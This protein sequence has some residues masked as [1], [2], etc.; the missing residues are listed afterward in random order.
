MF[1]EVESAIQK[2]ERSAKKGQKDRSAAL[3]DCNTMDRSVVCPREM[4]SQLHSYPFL[5]L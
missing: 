3:D 5:D 1:E 2:A 4:Y